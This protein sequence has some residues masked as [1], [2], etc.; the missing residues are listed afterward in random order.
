MDIQEEKQA[1]GFVLTISNLHNFVPDPNKS[2]S[3]RL[4]E[5]RAFDELKGKVKKLVENAA[6]DP[7]DDHHNCD[8][9]TFIKLHEVDIAKPK[10]PP[11]CAACKHYLF[12]QLLFGYKCNTCKAIYHEK[13][14]LAGEA[15]SLYGNYFLIF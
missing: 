13:C 12:G 5:E 3:I 9:S 14:F 11:K 4:K 15:N 2:F 6:P 10:P 7:T 8:F 1:N